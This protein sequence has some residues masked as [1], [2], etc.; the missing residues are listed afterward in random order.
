GQD[1]ALPPDGR[2]LRLRPGEDVFSVEAVALS[3]T[4]P[5]R[6]LYAYRLDPADAAWVPMGAERTATFARLA[7]GRY[8][9]RVRAGTASGAWSPHELRLPV[10]VVPPWWATAW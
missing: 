3:F 2:P 10:V 1:R 4:A 8:T 7:P 9:L 5:E 6:L